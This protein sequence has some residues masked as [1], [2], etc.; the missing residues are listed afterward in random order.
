MSDLTP[1]HRQ[2]VGEVTAHL[3]MAA[4]SAAEGT[5]CVALALVATTGAAILATATVYH[6]VAAWR[7]RPK[8]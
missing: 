4:I 5:L 2:A 3:G 6:L 7:D 1:E 8:R